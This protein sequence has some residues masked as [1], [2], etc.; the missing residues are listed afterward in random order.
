M[1][2]EAVIQLDGATA[3]YLM[4][5]LSMFIDRPELRSSAAMDLKVRCCI[6]RLAYLR[7]VAEGRA[8]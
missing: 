3:D 6:A 7:E 8:P 4:E 1:R 5:T 2:E